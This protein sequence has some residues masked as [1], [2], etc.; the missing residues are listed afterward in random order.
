ML[1]PGGVLC[2]P[3]FVGLLGRLEVNV[4]FVSLQW[5]QR[6]QTNKRPESFLCFSPFGPFVCLKLSN[7]GERS[8]RRSSPFGWGLGEIQKPAAGPAM[9]TPSKRHWLVVANL[10]VSVSI[11]VLFGGFGRKIEGPGLPGGSINY[12]GHPFSQKG[13]LT[14]AHMARTKTP[15]TRNLLRS[16]FLPEPRPPPPLPGQGLDPTSA[17]IWTFVCEKGS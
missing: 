4:W 9:N 12:Q 15:P 3:S 1:L 7:K 6:L 2:F 16:H 13:L 17:Q 10:E 14:W 5:T 11:G 8:F